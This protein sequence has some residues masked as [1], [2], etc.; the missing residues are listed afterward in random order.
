MD[1][2]ERQLRDLLDAA[3]G[4]PPHPVAVE[5]VRRRVIRRR[6]R[7]YLGAAVAVAVIAVVVPAG[8]GAFGQTLSPSAGGQRS[9]AACACL[10][11]FES[12]PGIGS[13]LASG[14]PGYRSIESFA[15]AAGMQPSLVGYYS[16]WE[17]PFALAFANSVHRHGSIPLV[18][19]V[20]ADVSASAI[21]SGSYDGYLS[22]YA[23]AVRAYGHSVV[24][25]FAPEANA[26]WWSYGY[27]HSPA[28]AFVAAWRHVVTLF[29]ALGADNVTWLWTIAA[30]VGGTGPISSWWPGASFV[31]WVGIDGFYNRPSD[32]FNS[33]FVSTIDQVRTLTS[34]PILLSE[35]GISRDANQL[36]N[37]IDLF[38][39]IAR[40]R[41]L[42]LMWCDYGQWRIDD[43]PLA[44]RAFRA[45]VSGLRSAQP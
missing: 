23:E 40:Y 7:Q 19:M 25:G 30:D 6:A 37:I 18:Q 29:R 24:I 16:L 5:A 14:P 41:I 2:M 34:R 39:G 43:S 42:G 22:A 36:T 4:E 9:S 21:A 27:G 20:P 8:V 12:G 44:E 35:T 17:R 45:G 26:D 31:S 1:D 3:A 11:V 32:T 13:S 15:R 38:A 28:R 33:V 10:G